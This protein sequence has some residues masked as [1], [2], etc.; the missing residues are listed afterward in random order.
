MPGA[1][2]ASVEFPSRARVPD[3]ERHRHLAQGGI[4]HV[5]AGT[6]VFPGGDRCRCGATL[7][8]MT[9]YLSNRDVGPTGCEPCEFLELPTMAP[10][11]E[12]NPA[13][14][15]VNDEFEDDDTSTA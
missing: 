8:S 3:P 13:T 4:D 10:A 9:M 14:P 6:R 11:V 15:E 1:V 2:I 7:T 12:P 5:R